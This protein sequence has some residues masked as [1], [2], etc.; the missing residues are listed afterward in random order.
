MHLSF[1]IA[2]VTKNNN[3]KASNGPG[4][5]ARVWRANITIE[6]EDGE[7]IVENC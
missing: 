5:Q 1:S 2:P 6:N 3:L 7:K 4:S